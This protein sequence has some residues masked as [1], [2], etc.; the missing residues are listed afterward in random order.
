MR[1]ILM[2]VGILALL[3]GIIWAGQGLG[4][5][6][7]TPPGMHP[8]FMIGDKHWTYYGAALAVVGLL[9]IMFSRRRSGGMR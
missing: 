9:V 1:F 4:Y 5:I 2:L 6:T 8:S 7:Y 3:A